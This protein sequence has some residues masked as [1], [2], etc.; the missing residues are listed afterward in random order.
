MQLTSWQSA[1]CSVW[2]QQLISITS[3][4]MINII[5]FLYSIYH[6]SISVIYQHRDVRQY[7]DVWVYNISGS[8]QVCRKDKIVLK[9]QMNVFIWRKDGRNQS[10]RATFQCHYNPLNNNYAAVRLRIYFCWN[11]PCFKNLLRFFL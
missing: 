3:C 11:F 5:T 1:Q 4:K 7:P 9:Y 6:N 8:A 2:W 10:S